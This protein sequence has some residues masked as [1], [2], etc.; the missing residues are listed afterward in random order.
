MTDNI[1]NDIPCNTTRLDEVYGIGRVE[2]NASLDWGGGGGGTWITLYNR[3]GNL[4]LR[5]TFTLLIQD[6]SLE[7]WFQIPSV[8]VY[9]YWNKLFEDKM[10]K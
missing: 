5:T 1:S 2:M 9:Q 6:L 4:Y 3:E 7:L 10:L 8:M